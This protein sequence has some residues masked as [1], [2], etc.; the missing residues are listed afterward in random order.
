MNLT[1]ADRQS[2]A[3]APEPA[4]APVVPPAPWDGWNWRSD[5]PLATIPAARDATAG[6]ELTSRPAGTLAPAAR[7]VEADVELTVPPAGTLTQPLP[8]DATAPIAW[9][10]GRASCRERV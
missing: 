2:P 1:D 3:P 6:P 8:T 9:Q 7:D 5:S 10:I 4:P